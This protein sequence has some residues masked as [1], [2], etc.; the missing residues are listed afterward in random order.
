MKDIVPSQAL[1]L[2]TLNFSRKRI[3]N[4]VTRQKNIRLLFS[5]FIPFKNNSL[6][7]LALNGI[8]RSKGDGLIC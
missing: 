4:V 1:F 8:I 3:I 5:Q 7:W 2:L 6:C